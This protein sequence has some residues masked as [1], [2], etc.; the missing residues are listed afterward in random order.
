MKEKTVYV[1]T[2]PTASGKSNAALRLAEK[3]RGEILCMD[4]MQVYR[5]MDVGT[6]KP[7]K[8]E[9]RRVPHH[10]LDLCDPAESFSVSDWAEHCRPLLSSVPVPILTGGTGLYLDAVSYDR[11]FGAVG[12]DEAIRAKYHAV[13]DSEGCARLHAILAARDSAA[14]AKLHPNDVRRVVRALEV[15]D[16]TGR[17]ITSFTLRRSPPGLRFRIFATDR[18]REELYRRIDRRADAMMASGLLEEVRALWEAGI[19]RTATAIQGIGYKELYQYF[20]SE[21]SLEEAVRTIRLRTRH[22]AKRQLTWFRHDPRVTWIPH[23][24]QDAADFI[25]N[26]AEE[27]SPAG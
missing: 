5:G 20:A 2:G 26:A 4:S 6:A 17:S 13:A 9:R 11:D 16:L 24:M 21:T 10:L 19:P 14:A 15:L 25:L 1:L 3:T 8:E 22:Y 12:A 27:D 18:P 23:G 7:T